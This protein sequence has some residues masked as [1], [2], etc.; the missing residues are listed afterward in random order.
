[1]AAD[2]FGGVYIGGSYF[3]TVDF[4][5][6]LG[7]YDLT[8]FGGS[9]L[10]L[11]KLNVNG[12]F[13]WAFNAGSTSTDAVTDIAVDIDNNVYIT[14]YFD[15]ADFDPG[16]GWFALNPPEKAG[17]IAKYK[18]DGSFVNAVDFEG[19]GPSGSNSIAIAPN[20]SLYVVGAFNSTIDFDPGVGT[21]NLTSISSN[22]DIYV[23]KLDTS[24]T[25]QWAKSFGSSSADNGHTVSVSD[26]DEPVITGGFWNTI[27]V[28]PGPST[29]NVTSNG[30]VDNLLL[31]LDASG[32]FMW[33]NTYGNAQTE[34]SLDA[35]IA[36][37]DDIYILGKFIDSI[38]V[39]GGPGTQ[40]IASVSPSDSYI[41]RLDGSGN[42]I[43]SGQ[44]GG[45]GSVSGKGLCISNTQ[46]IYHTGIFSG[47]AELDP[48]A[49]IDSL[50]SLGLNDSYIQIAIPSAMVGLKTIS[51][52]T[53][54]KELIKI[55]D[56]MG[57]YIKDQPNTLL[58]YVYSDGTTEKVFRVE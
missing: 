23:C 18:P 30:L 17:Y 25:F 6:G 49:G 20:G 19:D 2:D 56:I 43:S 22:V 16:A 57:R 45:P 53:T 58:I 39:D 37:N 10:F 4:D 35:A 12:D 28:D 3:N 26:S 9:D 7:V 36:V 27:D 38:D 24:L 44:L 32:N 34:Y 8:V 51:T 1:M 15:Y 47:S 33:A 41:A 48:S 31:K 11:S 21:F 55:I 13:E 42:L 46:K 5:P 14:G 40:L 54:K 52:E 29:Y 50:T